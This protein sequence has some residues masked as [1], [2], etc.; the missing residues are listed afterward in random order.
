MNLKYVILCFKQNIIFFYRLTIINTS[1]NEQTKYSIILLSEK[2][3]IYWLITNRIIL[4]I[5]L[6]HTYTTCFDSFR[7]K[8][9]SEP[10]FLLLSFSNI[11]KKSRHATKISLSSYI[12]H[13]PLKYYI[14]VKHNYTFD[15]YLTWESKTIPHKG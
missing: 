4:H 3:N 9:K 11:N 5:I 12:D 10:Q 2:Y 13:F 6:L 15:I 14:F 7:E 1:F 8:K